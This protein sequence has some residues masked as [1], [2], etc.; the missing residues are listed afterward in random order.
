MADLGQGWYG[1]NLEPEDA[2]ARIGNLTRLLEARGRRRSDVTIS[3]C[4]YLRPPSLDLVK[5]YRDAGVD[6]VIVFA[7]AG[8]ADGLRASLDALAKQVVEPAAR[9]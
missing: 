5:R 3:V 6:Q 4:P 2:K 9:L 8:N 1:Y 7:V